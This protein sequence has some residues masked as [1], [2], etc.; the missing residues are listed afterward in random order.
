MKFCFFLAP[1][2]CFLLLTGGAAAATV[3]LNPVKDATLYE[4]PAGGQ[5][6]GASTFLMTGRVGTNDASPRRRGLLQFDLS[7]IPAGATINSVQLTL[8]LVK[9]KNNNSTATTLQRVTG[10]WTEGTTNAG[11]SGNGTT[12]NP[13]DA[14]WLHRTS[15]TPWTNPGGDFLGTASST[16]NVGSL[17]SYT[18]GGAGL[19]TD[20]QF[21]LGNATQNFGWILRGDEVTPQSVKEFSSR[22]GA[23][24]P[25]LLINFTPVPEPSSVTLVL[26]VIGLAGRRRYV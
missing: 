10:A 24:D 14:T 8:Q 6:S 5:S 15:P 25:I 20:V 2:S 16:L 22:E 7:G 11:T 1:I 23:T 3:S 13:G 19:V 17:G 18:W 9:V 12:A 4:D 26:A 21:W